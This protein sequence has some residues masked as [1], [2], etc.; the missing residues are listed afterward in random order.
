VK[1]LIR[2]HRRWNFSTKRLIFPSDFGTDIS[3]VALQ[4]RAE[5]TGA[6]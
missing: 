1:R 6:T 3:G 4:K 5:S 2:C